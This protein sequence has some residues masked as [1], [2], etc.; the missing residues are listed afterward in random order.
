[1]NDD[2]DVCMIDSTP[3]NLV[4]RCLYDDIDLEGICESNQGIK[5]NLLEG[6]EDLDWEWS[7]F[8]IDETKSG[9]FTP[10]STPEVHLDPSKPSSS[11]S[12]IQHYPLSPLRQHHPSSQSGQQHLH[13]ILNEANIKAADDYILYNDDTK[14]YEE[15][16]EVN[17]LEGIEDLD[18]EWSLSEVRVDPA[19]LPPSSQLNQISPKSSTKYESPLLDDIPVAASSDG[20]S[21][22]AAEEEKEKDDMEEEENKVETNRFYKHAI[23]D[24]YNEAHVD[25]AD[26]GKYL[27]DD[28]ALYYGDDSKTYEEFEEALLLKN[29]AFKM[30]Q[31]L[32]KIKLH[33]MI[34]TSSYIF[35]A[36]VMSKGTT[37]AASSS[38]S[39]CPFTIK[40]EFPQRDRGGCTCFYFD[41]FGRDRFLKVTLPKE[42]KSDSSKEIGCFRANTNEL[43]EQG[44]MFGTRCFY[45]VNGK[46]DNSNKSAHFYSYRTTTLNKCMYPATKDLRENKINSIYATLAGF[47]RNR[48]FST[49]SLSKTNERV[50]LGFSRTVR[51]PTVR[52]YQISVID[53][54]LSS[55]VIT[56]TSTTTTTSVPASASVSPSV[57][58]TTA[59]V[60]SPSSDRRVMTDGCGFISASLVARIPKISKTF[61]SDSI[62]VEGREPG[63]G[64]PNTIQMRLSC[65]QGLFKGCLTVTRDES[66][67]KKDCIVLRKSMC[68]ERGSFKISDATDCVVYVNSTFESCKA[69]STDHHPH[70]HLNVEFALLLK[71]RGTFY[72]PHHH[73]CFYHHHDHY[74]DHYHHHPDRHHNYSIIIISLIILLIIMMIIMIIIVITIMTTII[75]TTI[76]IIRA[77]TYQID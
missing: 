56:T 18:W 58:T 40:I 51:G 2:D 33:K 43:Y 3:E 27:G 52:N 21:A 54:C 59:T 50:R 31:S 29:P 60:T 30:T 37:A 4:N 47:V 19:A 62:E 64:L 20:I 36:S 41:K 11:S 39:S 32:N 57:S 25:V 8:S 73:H 70:A 28:Y 66:L 6:I 69:D 74:Y 10:T 9:C 22:A 35:K 72:H 14:I 34:T 76:I 26:V 44:I 13:A 23:L 71:S 67:C 49:A 38:S 75:I 17:L 65:K 53:D 24:I 12:L 1:M 42:S 15:F 77:L 55:T 5:D 63:V 48:M 45:F 61:D 16:E 46:I 7:L 68:K